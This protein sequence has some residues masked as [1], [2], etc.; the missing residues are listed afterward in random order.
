[1]T[2][3]PNPNSGDSFV[4]RAR[5]G[6]ASIVILA[7]VFA[8][9][10]LV[11]VIGERRNLRI[12]LTSTREHTL[13]QR[14]GAMLAN[15]D[16]PIEIVINADLRDPATIASLPP[17][18]DLIDLFESASDRIRVT[19]V[20]VGA[21]PAVSGFTGVIERL[22]AL[23]ER[24]I[25]E[26][27]RVVN[28]AAA[29][30]RTL[31]DQLAALI[32]D[33]DAGAASLPPEPAAELKRAVV[34]WRVQ[35]DTLARAVEEAEAAASTSFAGVRIP[36]SDRAIGALD[37]SLRAL[38]TSLDGGSR[39]LDQHA[40]AAD[41]DRARTLGALAERCARARD[42]AA[43][44]AD[45]LD[46]LAPLEPLLLT[47]LLQR[48]QAIVVFSARG[49]TAINFDSMFPPAAVLDG[50]TSAA[51]LFTGEELI[52]T[53]IGSMNRE[54]NPI[55]VLVHAEPVSVL[56]GDPQADTLGLRI[57]GMV[58]KL[59]LR[60]IDVTE[61]RVTYDA[62]RP[63]LLDINPDGSRPVVWMVLRAPSQADARGA[64]GLAAADRA[65]GTQRL[66]RAL[67]ELLDS[68]E[69]VLIS[70][71]PSELPVIGEPDPMVEPLQRFGIRPD[72]GRMLLGVRPSA[73]GKSVLAF[74]LVRSADADSPVGASI[75]GLTTLLPWATAM[76]LEGAPEGIT[77]A[78]IIT[79]DAD[80]AGGEVWAESQWRVWRNAPPAPVPTATPPTPDPDR[81]GFADA[82]T[83][84]ASA[85]VA[86]TDARGRHQRVIVIGSPAWHEDLFLDAASIVEGRRVFS[87]PGN[88][89]LLESS[90]AWLAGQDELVA[91]SPRVRDIAR[92]GPLTPGQL[93]AIRWALAAGLPVLVLT[94]GAG[95]RILRG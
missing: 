29:D 95:V 63:T 22:A 24:P 13:S 50:S 23:S 17:V 89:G 65:M 60:R 85:E 56:D 81:D 16:E 57:A 88:A 75:N 87:F 70:L 15:L 43:T 62:L 44:I 76:K 7:L 46:Q 21:D 53:A 73:Q 9:A 45:E 66:A 47:R 40:S 52:A 41:D 92:I 93:A 31:A 77:T 79:V 37:P 58:E 10:V 28:T 91:P 1:M 67:G 5:Y 14:T 90:I 6:V 20:D 54:D 42:A 25:A 19:W 74:Q 83:L 64:T 8:S 18:R 49:A 80:A 12:D 38:A 72:T 33:L 59:R 84:A 39:W 94:I 55:V 11:T 71:E 26:H 82:W 32:D 36:E 34:G 27:T 78:P 35:H 69:S 48:Q 2:V 30:A 3:S 86:R 68:A 4:R 51:A 61:W